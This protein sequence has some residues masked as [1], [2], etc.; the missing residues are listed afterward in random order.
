M[1]SHD[2]FKTVKTNILFQRNKKQQQQ[3]RQDNFVVVFLV[4]ARSR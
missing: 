1:T 4:D 2:K 3:L